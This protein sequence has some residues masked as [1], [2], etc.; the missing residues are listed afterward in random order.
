LYQLVEMKLL[1]IREDG[2]YRLVAG[3]FTKRSITKPRDWR[4]SPPR[5]RILT[6]RKFGF[7]FSDPQTQSQNY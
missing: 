1:K 4:A 3:L 2:S 6:E 5:E 7:C